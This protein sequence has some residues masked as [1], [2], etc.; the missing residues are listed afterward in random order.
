MAV[1]EQ[2]QDMFASP[3]EKNYSSKMPI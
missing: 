3:K 2:V 1:L